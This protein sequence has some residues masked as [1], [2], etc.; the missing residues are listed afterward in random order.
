MF[1]FLVLEMQETMFGYLL[2]IMVLRASQEAVFLVFLLI[3]MMI[4][5]DLLM[6]INQ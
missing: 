2:K 3:L 1:L 5:M 6:K 4:V